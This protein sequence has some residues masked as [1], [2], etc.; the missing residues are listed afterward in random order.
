MVITNLRSTKQADLWTR[1]RLN[2]HGPEFQ[3]L[4]TAR[5]G[6]AWKGRMAFQVRSTSDGW[7]GWFPVDFVDQYKL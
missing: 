7:E 2:A 1:N 5:S 3:I 4:Q 6:V